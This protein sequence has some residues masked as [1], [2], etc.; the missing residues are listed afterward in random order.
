VTYT[1][2]DEPEDFL[3]DEELDRNL[4]DTGEYLVLKVTKRRYNTEDMVETLA[5]HTNMGRRR[6][7]YAGNK[8][9]QAITTQ[10]VSVKGGRPSEFDEV[11]LKDI[12]VEVSGYTD[13]PINLGDLKGNHFTIKARGVSE[14]DI[15]RKNRFVNYFDEQRFSS[16]NHVIGKHI[17]KDRWEDAVKILQDDDYHGEIIDDHLSDH[18]ND[19]KTALRQLPGNLLQLFVH[20]YQSQ[21]WNRCVKENLDG[22][23]HGDTFPLIG[24]GTRPDN[25]LERKVMKEVMDDEDITPRSFIIR[26]IP[27]LSAEGTRRDVYKAIEDLSVTEEQGAVK[28]S[29]YLEKGSYATMALKHL[30]DNVH[31][32]K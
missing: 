21:L 27:E 30:L 6:F 5:E 1:I 3:V 31:V 17:V 20:A 23:S 4:A 26:S 29:F 19:Y 8:D 24:F 9:R 22:L 16:A 2:K 28:I 10:H 12:E 15:T 7:G 14:S 11:S 25:D 32:M 13:T 18:P